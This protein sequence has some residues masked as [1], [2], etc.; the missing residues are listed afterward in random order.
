LILLGI[1]YDSERGL[2]MAKQ[3]MAIIHAESRRASRE[4]AYERG[5]F[6]NFQKSVHAKTGKPLRNATL[7]TIAPTGTLALIAGCS[8][9]IEPIYGIST[10]RL[11]MEKIRLAGPHP[12][13]IRALRSAGF[14]KK[15]DLLDLSSRGSIQ[16]ETRIPRVIRSLFPTAHDISP[17]YHIR[18]QAAFQ[19]ETENGVS[20][21]VNFPKSADVNA[22]R[23]AFFLAHREGCKG[24]TVFRSGARE[25]QVI[26]CL[27]TLYC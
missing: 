17:E 1:P 19:A 11:A 4:L 8:S 6:P 22:I 3:V 23:K 14:T 7:T 9:G 5:V 16:G 26:K 24:V 27:D 10:D 21:T 20:K 12:L 2:R 18:M 15:K 13:F 25:G